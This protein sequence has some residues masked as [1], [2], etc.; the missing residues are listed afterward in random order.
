MKFVKKK[1]KKIHE[2][3][4]EKKEKKMADEP[5]SHHSG[6]TLLYTEQ[7]TM[8]RSFPGVHNDDTTSP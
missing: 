5:H 1:N 7:S 4:V 2:W 3:G 8:F 6:N